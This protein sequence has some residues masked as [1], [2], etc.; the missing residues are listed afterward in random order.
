LNKPA[1]GGTNR[2]GEVTSGSP[3]EIRAISVL[4]T[5]VDGAVVYCSDP[6]ICE[7]D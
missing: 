1:N 4:A 6:A 7:Q 3:D 5:I 2:S